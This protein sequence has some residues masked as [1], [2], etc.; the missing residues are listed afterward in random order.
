RIG[1]SCST[2]LAIKNPGLKWAATRPGLT[3]EFIMDSQMI[4]SNRPLAMSSREIADLVESRHDNVRVN[5][6]RL[7]SRAVI[8]LPAMQEKAAAGRPAKGYVFSGEHGTR[9]RVIVGVERCPWLTGRRVERGQGVESRPHGTVPRTLPSAPRLAADLA[10][11]NN[12]P[13]LVV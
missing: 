8:A 13:R 3:E 4:F 1:T 10:E 6:E 7:A 9:D 12:S 5:I 11:E 2:L